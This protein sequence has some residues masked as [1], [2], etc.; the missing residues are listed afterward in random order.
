MKNVLLTNN[1]SLYGKRILK[2]FN[3]NNIVLSAIVVVLQ[4]ISYYWKLFRYVQRK[5][6][7]SD[8]IYFSFIR[9]LRH[10]PVEKDLRDIAY[11]EF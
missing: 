11:E 4:P 5:V 10:P 9:S 3:K 6:G 2:E 8:A 7:I 1:G